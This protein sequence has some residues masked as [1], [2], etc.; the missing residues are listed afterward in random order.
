M[1]VGTWFIPM[2]LVVQT[3]GG[4]DSSRFLHRHQQRNLTLI[5]HAHKVADVRDW[6][7]FGFVG[8]DGDDN[9]M[10]GTYAWLDD[11]TVLF[12]R[13]VTPSYKPD[14][15]FSGVFPEPPQGPTAVELYALDTHTSQERALPELS[16]R[17]NQSQ[18][19]PAWI[20]TSP[21]GKWVLWPAFNDHGSLVA[22]TV[23]GASFVTI[24]SGAE[25]ACWLQDSHHV[26]ALYFQDLRF[27]EALIYDIREKDFK[28]L[29]IWMSDTGGRHMRMLGSIGVE[30]KL[31]AKPNFSRLQWLPDGK[32]LSFVY[33]EAL[34]TVPAK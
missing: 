21:D 30:S 32:Q 28:R 26:L 27:E 16:K 12:M 5:A 19:N 4:L 1:N 11:H 23:N 20:R 10:D 33:K 8:G 9:E 29:A 6:S 13:H 18:G 2:L 17:F 22:A 25:E 3:I 31:G 34:W 15:S 24:D 14:T 7:L